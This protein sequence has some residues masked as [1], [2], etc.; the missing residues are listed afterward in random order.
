MCTRFFIV[1]VL[2]LLSQ[3]G[4]LLVL[5]LF[6][7]ILF[8][9]LR[10]NWPTSDHCIIF[11]LL[12]VFWCQLKEENLNGNTF[13]CVFVFMFLVQNPGNSFFSQYLCSYN[14]NNNNKVHRGSELKKK[15]FVVATVKQWSMDT[16][17][18]TLHRF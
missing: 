5:G 16:D 8:A 17:S 12:V 2:F 4:L 1:V 3:F 14:N 9:S 13:F 15:S 10:M 7:Q 6:Q 11:R 18:N